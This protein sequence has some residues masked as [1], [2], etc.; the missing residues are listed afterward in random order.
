MRLGTR[1]GRARIR[2]A[3]FRR[4]RALAMPPTSAVTFP[5]TD[6]RQRTMIALTPDFRLPWW[7]WGWTDITAYVRWD[8]GITVTY[9]RQDQD[10][11]V[12]SLKADM[13]IDNRDSRFSRANPFGPYAGYLDRATPIWSQV[14]P[15][16]GWITILQGYVNSWPKRWDTTGGDAY[17]PIIVGGIMR[18]YTITDESQSAMT[19]AI[20]G[21]TASGSFAAAAWPMEDGETAFRFASTIPGVQP[22]VLGGDITLATSD[23][24]AGSLALPIWQAGSNA[25]GVVPDYTD[26]GRWTAVA[27]VL[28]PFDLTVQNVAITVFRADVT[29]GTYSSVSVGIT[30]GAQLA[31]VTR[32]SA[33]TVVDTWT[34]TFPS[35][36]VF[37]EEVTVSVTATDDADGTNDGWAANLIA[38]DG[39][40][41]ASI[42]QTSGA[43]HYGQIR[44][45]RPNGLLALASDTVIGQVGVWTDG[46][47]EPGVDDVEIAK[48]LNAYDGETAVARMRRACRSAGVPFHCTTDESAQLGPQPEGTL[49]DVLNDGEKGD[50]GVVYEYEFGYAFKPRA[51]FLLPTIA[52]T[53]DQAQGQVAG[54]IEAEDDDTTFVNQFTA[55][56]PSGSFATVRDPA[57]QRGKA[58]VTGGDTYNI[59][60]D[61][62]LLDLASLAV[63][64]GSLEAD[65]WP[66]ISFNL[67]SHPE[68]I[69][70]WASMPQFAR[71]VVESP[72]VQ[73]AVDRIDVIAEGATVHVNSRQWEVDLNASPAAL[74]TGVGVWGSDD[75]S[76]TDSRWGADDTTL[77]ADITSSQTSIT[78]DTGDDVWAV[79]DSV[80]EPETFPFNVNIG[81]AA[82]F[83]TYSCTAITGTHPN[84]TM[85]IVRLGTDRA[86]PAGTP[87]TV[88][89]TGIWG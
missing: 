67:G 56:R 31:L 88:T 6:L 26:T 2:P 87:V 30:Q 37:G 35:D 80:S 45:I 13:T 61:E 18:R 4:A 16:S 12:G 21:Y 65:R 46:L 83:L 15:G 82:A 66:R 84:L 53:L 7:E 44:R 86:W 11:R 59:Y 9:G 5:V 36:R 89:D 70:A 28:P 19:R 1:I 22:M 57:Y 77:A 62:Q 8:P 50:G 49:Q 14:N 54:E 78:V 41:L 51:E 24:I 23:E 34:D 43:G 25:T 81:P 58:L 79:A 29:G 71:L 64:Q 63:A 68:L 17:L 60:S 47:F 72:F 42:S 73:A 38:A 3:R 32:D 33:G 48:G 40:I 74:L 52:L 27:S 20:S 39:T 10:S 76:D 69:P 55:K 85:T 75:G